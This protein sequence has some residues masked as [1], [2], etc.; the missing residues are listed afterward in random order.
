MR[1]KLEHLKTHKDNADQLRGEVQEGQAKERGI[2]AQISSLDEQLRSKDAVS[3][4]LLELHATGFLSFF[5]SVCFF[6][7]IHA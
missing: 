4:K 7:E 3:Q 6:V 1:L 5:V 2:V